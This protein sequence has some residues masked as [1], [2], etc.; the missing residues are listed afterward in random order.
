MN[1]LIETLGGFLWG[2]PMLTV[3]LLTGAYF[4]LRSRVFPVRRFGL[5][6]KMTFGSLFSA[7]K[8]QDKHSISQWQAMTGALAACLG[9]GNIV[10]VASFPINPVTL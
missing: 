4:M 9:T 2:P 6:N 8:T 3:F 5:W 7:K 10:G 1:V